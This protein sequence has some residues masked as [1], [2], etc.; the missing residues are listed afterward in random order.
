MWKV[1]SL[2][3]ISCQIC[4][5][6]RYTTAL[7]LWT[8]SFR[9][10]RSCCPASEGPS[11]S[12]EPSMQ[13][14]SSPFSPTWPRM[15][16]P[17]FNDVRWADM[18]SLRPPP[19]PPSNI[20]IHAHTVPTVTCSFL[21]SVSMPVVVSVSVSVSWGTCNQVFQCIG[22]RYNTKHK[23]TKNSQL[24]TSRNYDQLDR[25]RLFLKKPGLWIR[26]RCQCLGSRKDECAWEPLGQGQG[27][28]MIHTPPPPLLARTFVTL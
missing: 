17:R 10:T 21:M 19:S 16:R 9:P 14:A 23:T 4:H 18:G 20:H 11:P 8:W 12:W 26:S 5:P 27:V 24:Y 22:F 25:A 13:S 3:T 28:C 6:W 2:E 15:K 7:A 1:C